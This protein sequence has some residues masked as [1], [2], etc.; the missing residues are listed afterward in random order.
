LM[1]FDD[2]WWFLMIFCLWED[3]DDHGS[4]WKFQRE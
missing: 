4:L 2:V 3:H 1:I